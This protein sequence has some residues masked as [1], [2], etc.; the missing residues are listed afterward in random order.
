MYYVM[1]CLCENIFK[2][3][4]DSK[5]FKYKIDSKFLYVVFHF[6]LFAS[7][8]NYKNLFIINNN[9]IKIYNI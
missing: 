9:L 8:K 1:L 4:I 6:K 7:E 3:K 5:F 2:Y